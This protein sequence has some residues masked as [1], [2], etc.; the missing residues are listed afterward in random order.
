MVDAWEKLGVALSEVDRADEA[1]AALQEAMRLTNGAPQIA[2]TMADVLLR[3]GRLDEAEEH[4]EIALS[5]HELARDVL[6]QVA[7]R[8]GDLDRAD[9]LALEAIETRGARLAPLITLAD[10]RF[11]Q[12]RYEEALELSQEVLDEFGAR[13]DSEKLRG[14]YFTRGRALVQLGDAPQAVQAFR[15]EIEISPDELAPYTHLA[16]LYALVGEGAQAGE[17]LRRLVEANPTARAY[18]EAVRT[19]RAMGD[20]RSAQALIRA[21]RQRFPDDPDLRRLEQG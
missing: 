20:A 5:V 2:L 21:A 18:A 1:V 12:E 4:A 11:K 7:L 14:I 8:K 16:Y 17:T 9:R 6:T 3:L 15:R 10:L 13:T 19:L